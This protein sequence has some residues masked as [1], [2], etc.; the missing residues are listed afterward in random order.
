M[1]AAVGSCKLPAGLLK[2]TDTPSD[3]AAT[4]IM[5]GLAGSCIALFTVP[6]FFPPSCCKLPADM[7]GR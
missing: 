7:R 3:P 6:P 2:A 5:H 4:V 1:L